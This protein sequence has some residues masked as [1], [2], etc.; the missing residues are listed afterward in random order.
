[1]RPLG[2]MTG[3]VIMAMQ[4]HLHHCRLNGPLCDGTAWAVRRTARNER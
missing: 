4:P 3:T 1:M 2:N